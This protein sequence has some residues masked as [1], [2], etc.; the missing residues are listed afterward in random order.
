MEPAWCWGLSEA[1]ANNGSIE[2]A[3][4]SGRP[5]TTRTAENVDAVGDLVQSQENNPRHTAPLDRSHESLE[6]LKQITGDDFPF[7]F[8][9]N[10]NEQ[11]IIAF[12]TDKCCYLNLR[13]KVYA[14]DEIDVGHF[15]AMLLIWQINKFFS[16]SDGNKLQ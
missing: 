1:V 2:R 3:P 14:Q 8:A 7:C 11:R 6:Y 15:A 9:M 4:D 16:G 13:S 10:V 5:R 12:L